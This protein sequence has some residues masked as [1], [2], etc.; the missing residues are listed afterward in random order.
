MEHSASSFQFS[1]TMT[2]V[3]DPNADR[4]GFYRLR[5]VNPLPG[6]KP[7][8]YKILRSSS[9]NY[10]DSK[11]NPDS[12]QQFNSYS[13]KY[14]Q[15]N[16]IGHIICLNSDDDSCKEIKEKLDAA[17]PVI[18]FTRLSVKDYH[19]PTL[20]QLKEGYRRYVEVKKTTLVWCGYGKGRTG[21]MITALQWQIE[22]AKGTTRKI[23]HQQYK[24]NG[25]EQKGPNGQTTGQYEVLDDLQAGKKSFEA[26][27]VSQEATVSTVGD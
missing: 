12:T 20:E 2:N 5:T 23:S 7:F 21:T 15:D 24:D 10:D 1:D 8:D 13:I 3:T 11:P 14:L 27:E 16:H 6:F 17:S 19:A 26:E 18:Q 4:A 25:V 9:P 22:K